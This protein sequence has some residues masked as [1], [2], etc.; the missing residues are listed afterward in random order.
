MRL[1]SRTRDGASE[2]RWLSVQLRRGCGGKPDPRLA[3]GAVAQLGGPAGMARTRRL[4]AVSRPAGT[5]EPARAMER[6]QASRGAGDGADSGAAADREGGIAAPLD[7]YRR[8]PRVRCL[9]SMAFAAFPDV[10]AAL[11]DPACA[12]P[13]SDQT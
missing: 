8:H 9:R 2:R 7:H 13:P 11:A 1:W 3:R 12:V 10:P 4:P 6:R 5:L